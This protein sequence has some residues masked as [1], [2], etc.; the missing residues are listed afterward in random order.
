MH[1]RRRLDH[2]L[3]RRPAARHRRADRRQ[4][5]RPA[6]RVRHLRRALSAQ[7]HRP[8]PEGVR[9][10]AGRRAQPRARQAAR[11]AAP[12]ARP[13]QRI[14]PVRRG[15]AVRQGG[16]AR[17]QRFRRRPAGLDP[18]V[19]GLG[20]R[21]RRLHLLHHPG[22]GVGGDLRPDRQAGMED[23]SGLRQAAGASAAAQA[24]LRDHRRVDQ[25]Q[26]Q[27]RGHGY[28][29]PARHSGRADPVDEGDRRGEVAAR[30]RHRGRGRPPGARQ[31]SHRRQSGEDVGLDHRGEALAAARRAH[32]GD[33]EQGAG[34]FGQG[35]RG[36]Q[37]SG[38]ITAP[39]KPAKA[40]AA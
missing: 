11:P 14:Q 40:E 32:R 39:E 10:D 16:A 19:Q 2:R 6:S 4:R 22:A 1:R 38:A 30:H 13:A 28:L 29:Q 20:D 18:E 37:G 23:R 12:R 8:R 17:R 25:D 7:P 24:H 5:H 9:R 35:G 3:P 34:L 31:V 33:P 21:S 27:V 26:D 15:R 36:D